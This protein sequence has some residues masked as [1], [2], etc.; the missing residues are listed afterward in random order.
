MLPVLEILYDCI[1]TYLLLHRY[2]AEEFFPK[3]KFS[4]LYLCRNENM[5]IFLLLL[6]LSWKNF[7]NFDFDCPMKQIPKKISDPNSRLPI[8][9]DTRTPL[10]TTMV[11]VHTHLNTYLH[12][13]AHMGILC[14][15][16]HICMQMRAHTHRDKHEIRYLPCFPDWVTLTAVKVYFSLLSKLFQDQ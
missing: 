14:A 1:F 5:V 3:N 11:H 13:F 12:M 10:V 8:I 6:Y 16:T 9:L 15:S 7:I 2:F 4:F